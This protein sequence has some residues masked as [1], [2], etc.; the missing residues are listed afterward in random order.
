MGVKLRMLEINKKRLSI[1]ALFL[2][3]IIWGFGYVGVQ[4]ALDGGWTS[5]GILAFRGLVGGAICLVFS[6]K[7]KWWKNPKFIYGCLASGAITFLGYLF[8]TEGQQLTSIPNTSFFTALNVVMV[9]FFATFLFKEKFNKKSIVASIVALI[10]IGILSFDGS[11]FSF[12]IGD[13]L[14]FLGAVCFAVQIAHMTVLSKYGCPFAVAGSQLLIMGILGMIC[15]PFTGGMSNFGSGGW[16]GILYVAVI[17]SCVAFF[18][19][20]KCQRYVASGVTAIIIA[21]ESLFGTIFSIIFYHNAVTPQ[22]I[23]GGFIVLCGVIM[24]SVD[25][26]GI[27]QKIKTKRANKKTKNLPKSNNIE[28]PNEDNNKQSTF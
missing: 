25:F 26:S 22:L 19:Q 17:S 20:A 7:E 11:N 10:G 13:L 24:A 14:N 9:P 21:Q 2:T 28:E 6:I 3:A 4:D 15:V 23:I 8:Q 16:L 5:I 18:L 1:A 12:H 27:N